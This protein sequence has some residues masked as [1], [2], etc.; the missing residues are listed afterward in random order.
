MRTYYRAQ[1][2]LLNGLWWP[3]WE[4]NLKEKGVYVQLVHF[5]VQ[6]ELTTM[7]S[8]YTPIKSFKIRKKRKCVEDGSHTGKYCQFWVLPP[9]A[10]GGH[11][12]QWPSPTTF[13]GTNFCFV[14]WLT[15][16]SALV[17]LLVIKTGIFRS[18]KASE[19]GQRFLNV[20]LHWK[21][22]GKAFLLRLQTEINEQM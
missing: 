2:T 21:K 20:C 7:K 3:K 4:G 8:N 5:A 15:W 18:N 16:F 14:C 9:Q 17:R 11:C 22:V 13:Q 19:K 1:G 12:P 10:V 6:Q